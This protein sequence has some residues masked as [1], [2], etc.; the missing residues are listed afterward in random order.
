MEELEIYVESS[1]NN[2]LELGM[3]KAQVKEALDEGITPEETPDLWCV[4]VDGYNSCTRMAY[5]RKFRQ[6]NWLAQCSS[7]WLSRADPY[8]IGIGS[9]GGYV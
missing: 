9:A 5:Y 1:L 7:L 8:G 6:S 4:M 2:A 3:T